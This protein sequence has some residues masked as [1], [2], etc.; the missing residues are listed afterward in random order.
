MGL[1]FLAAYL[2]H[3]Y[4]AIIL[5]AI[6]GMQ[7]VLE[8]LL[9][10]E[11]RLEQHRASALALA[12]PLLAIAV[13]IHWQNQDPVYRASAAS[14]FGPQNLSVFWYPVT[15]GLVGIAAVRGVVVWFGQGRPY[16]FA[17][18]S[19]VVAVVLLH[20]SP[21]LNG[22]KFV[23]WLHLPVCILAAPVVSDT[24]ER[25]RSSNVRGRAIGVVALVVL[26]GQAL[27]LPIY[28]TRSVLTQHAIPVEYALVTR[29]LSTKPAGNVMAPPDL[30]NILPAF[31]PHH[32]WVGHWFLTP[33]YA[34]KANLYVSFCQNAGQIEAFEKVLEQQKI[35]YLVIPA[36][37]ANPID[38]R[39]GARIKERQAIGR[40][41]LLTLDAKR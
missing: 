36:S 34:E 31:T 17:M 29:V 12:V 18:V 9:G 14:I 37:R 35:R 1:A 4:T 19:W 27:I 23:F 2:I 7:P 28:S 22:Y 30:G 5:V 33:N 10:A 16:R 40:L 20:S 11:L 6:L 38:A 39:L 21:I 41:W 24:A 32:V 25:L 8:L 3:P 13:L 15:L 26:G